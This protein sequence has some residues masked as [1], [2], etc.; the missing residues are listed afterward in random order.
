MKNKV[1][2]ITGASKGFGFEIARAA[3]ASGDQVVATVRKN[4][5]ELTAR[6]DGGMIIKLAASTNPPLHLPV[7]PD[8]GKS[9]RD[10]MAQM[11]REVEEWE[12]VSMGTD[13]MA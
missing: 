7:G 10:K 5:G 11:T 9:F 4:A 13:K 8:A 6:L 2:F 12:T 1:W 3:L